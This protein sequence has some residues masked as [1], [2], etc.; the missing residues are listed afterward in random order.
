VR[1]AEFMGQKWV[2]DFIDELEKVDKFF[3]RKVDTLVEEFTQAEVQFQLKTRQADSPKKA[4]RRVESKKSGTFDEINEIKQMPGKTLSEDYSKKSGFFKSSL[5]RQLSLKDR[6]LSRRKSIAMDSSGKK[7]LRS[8]SKGAESD[9]KGSDGV[10]TFKRVGKEKDEIEAATNW[11]RVFINIY[12]QLKWLNAFA[13]IN[14][15]AEEKSVR[16]FMKNYFAVQNNVLD[17]KLLNCIQ[18][19]HSKYRDRL[20]QLLDELVNFY[21]EYFCEGSKHLAKKHLKN[22]D[23]SLRVSDAINLGMSMGIIIALLPFLVFFWSISSSQEDNDEYVTSSLP[24]FRLCFIVSVFF[25][26]AGI[27][28]HIFR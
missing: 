5:S 26:G 25:L 4:L 10:G 16:K 27:C 9:G 12:Q 19:L 6:L 7:L 11:N 22:Q 15:I 23:S 1:D 17:K 21:A 13:K 18:T 14:F 3:K 28:I 8:P 20:H 24:V 2:K